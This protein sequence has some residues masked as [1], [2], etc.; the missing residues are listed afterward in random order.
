MQRGKGLSAYVFTFLFRNNP[1]DPHECMIFPLSV[2]ESY[3]NWKYFH[4]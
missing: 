4:R 2:S 3:E 1:L